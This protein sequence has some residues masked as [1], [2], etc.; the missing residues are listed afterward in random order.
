MEL[1]ILD[2]FGD[3]QSAG[4]L[5]NVYCEKDLRIVGHLETAAFRE[6]VG[7][8]VLYLRGVSELEYEHITQAHRMLF[9]SVY[10]WA[11]QD[12]L[13]TAP[14]LKILKGGY[15]NLFALPDSIRIAAE[16]ALRLGK[17]AAHLRAHPGEVFGYLAHAHPFLEW[18]G[19]TILTVYAEMTR[20]SGF[21]VAWEAI[22]KGAFLRALTEELL[23]PGTAMDALVLPYMRDGVLAMENVADRL[24][25]NFG[26][27]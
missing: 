27:E 14:H 16:Y 4:Y 25:L 22:E 9:G 6:Q 15:K 18:N 21:H 20:R 10:P 26:R 7:Q 11:G 13:E 5:R 3:F 17:D 24:D 2:P 23:Q 19:R 12:R 8:T 1:D